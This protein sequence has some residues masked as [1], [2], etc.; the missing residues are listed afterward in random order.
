[1]LVKGVAA[2]VTWTAV[3]MVAVRWTRAPNEK[4]KLTATACWALVA[5]AI[6][7]TIW[8]PPVSSGLDRVTRV[9]NL[10]QWLWNACV[11][12]TGYFVDT[13]LDML[14]QDI[15]GSRGRRVGRCV[16]LGVALCL[17]AF[18]LWQAGLRRDVADFTPEALGAIPPP[19]L[20][21][22][23][24][25]YALT[26]SIIVWRLLFFAGRDARASRDVIVKLGTSLTTLGAG[27]A[28]VYFA[29]RMPLLL[30][31]PQTGLSFALQG[32]EQSSMVIAALGTVCGAS[33]PVWGRH[34]RLRKVSQHV[35]VT[36]TVWQLRGLW[37]T[38]A[39]AAPDTVLPT[40][41]TP[42]SALLRPHEMDVL[43][44]RRVIEILD[45]RRMVLNSNAAAATTETVQVPTTWSSA[46]PP[47]VTRTF[48]H[49]PSPSRRRD[50][51]EPQSAQDEE[52]NIAA[53]MRT[54]AH[55]EA[56]LMA[57]A[58]NWRSSSSE[59]VFRSP[60]QPIS[61]PLFEAATFHEQVRY[62]KQLAVELRRVEEQTRA[63]SAT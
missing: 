43:L 39:A 54:A 16:V 31:M 47:P 3:G 44:T 28:L 11:L 5:L 53:W 8:L 48:P 60:G 34:V 20:V 15:P 51:N 13:F 6:A 33:C 19:A 55:A 46:T 37:R 62:L 63:P 26:F 21:A 27:A 41:M 2:A 17:M 30:L 22:Y 57:R 23:Q 32:I 49:V 18:F 42:L 9:P 50:R 36:L 7:F 4:R 25:V 45:A 14:E 56:Q 38:L 59:E 61:V 12:V 58:L 10:A 24:L 1:M 52:M 29:A 40:A 35:D